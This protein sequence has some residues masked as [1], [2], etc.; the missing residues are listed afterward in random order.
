MSTNDDNS[1]SSSAGGRDQPDKPDNSSHPTDTALERFVTGRLAGDAAAELEE[2]IL[3]C[4]RCAERIDPSI[5][6]PQE[7]RAGF[8]L[9]NYVIKHRLGEGGMGIVYEAEH[10]TLR[11]RVALKVLSTRS[12][13]NDS[14]IQRFLSE[15]R[16][17]GRLHHT[18]IVPVFE[19]G[20]D[21][22]VHYYAMQLIEGQSLDRVVSD[23]RR[24]Q[25]SALTTPDGELADTPGSAVEVDHL[26][27]SVAWKFYLGKYD[28]SKKIE[29]RSSRDN[30]TKIEEDGIASGANLTKAMEAGAAGIQAGELAERESTVADELPAATSSSTGRRVRV[31]Y[32][33]RVAQIGLQVA[34]ALS[35]AH[36]H[37][38]LH[39]DIKPGN[40]LLD[41]EG[42]AWI[43]DF[44]L[45]KNQEDDLT[46]S[47]DLV[48]TFRYMAPEQFNGNADARTDVYALGLTM[49]ELCT[50][51]VAYVESDRGRLINDIF[52]EDP[53]RLRS[54]DR[55]IPKDLETIVL[56]S[57]D[58][59]PRHRYPTA[60]K[61]ATDLRLFLEDRPI[62]ARR[63]SVAE[64]AWRLCRRNP[65]SA[66]LA[67]CVILLLCVVLVGSLLHS[68]R[69]SSYANLLELENDRAV[70]AEGEAN[71]RLY[72]QLRTQIQLAPMDQRPGQRFDAGETLRQAVELL[73]KLNLPEL[74]YQEQ[75]RELRNDAIHI[76]TRFDLEE[77][78]LRR[79][80]PPWTGSLEFSSSHNWYANSDEDGNIAIRRF[81]DDQEIA[82]LPSFGPNMRAWFMRFSGNDRYLSAIYH[83]NPKRLAVW[84][85]ESGKKV[86]G[87]QGLSYIETPFLANGHQLIVGLPDGEIGIYEL[88]DEPS[89]EPVKTLSFPGRPDTLCYSPETNQLAVFGKA[90]NNLM[91]CN[92][93][94]GTSTN[95]EIGRHLETM[96]WSTSGTL[97]GACDDGSI[98]IWRSTEDLAN[99]EIVPAHRLTVRRITFL[100]GT[101]IVAT[102]SNEGFVRFANIDSGQE[103]LRVMGAVLKQSGFASNGQKIGF[104]TLENEFGLWELPREIPWRVL[105]TDGTFQPLWGLDFWPRDER[106]LA[107]ATDTGVEFWDT[108]RP[109]LIKSLDIGPTKTARFTAD[110]SKLLTSGD[111]GVRLWPVE[112]DVDSETSI[113]LGEPKVVAAGKWSR[114]AM[115]AGAARIVTADPQMQAF[116]LSAPSSAPLKMRHKW[117]QHV[118]MKPDGKWFVSTTWLGT[119]V[120]VW[121]GASG[122]ELRDL[123]PDSGSATCALS[124]DGRWLGVATG[125]ENLVWDTETW[126]VVY[127]VDR[128]IADGVP[129]PIAFSPDSRLM[130]VP[131][132]RQIVQLIDPTSKRTLGVL[133]SQRLGKLNLCATFSPS[134]QFLAVAN[135]EGIHIW[136]IKRMRERLH[137]FDL[138]WE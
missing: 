125:Q 38:V 11:R 14:Y 35:Y 13:S 79:I 10:V 111:H 131:Y 100:P 82:L 94:D 93:A 25:P 67:G 124:D 54:V 2:H 37:G 96:A 90:A 134:G 135:D 40:I 91:I 3:N 132:S 116:D 19:V 85:I 62:Q 46:R 8:Q 117:A 97:A 50:L 121:D 127:Q 107:S 22:G 12:S 59:Q 72:Q 9:G 120:K 77:T 23:V 32:H 119:G 26:R 18:N 126:E 17:A 136:D 99:P 39:R 81:A 57:I 48:G 109:R 63:I 75:R 41:R 30:Q 80:H 69:V 34:E 66:S 16:S 105:G 44:G 92:L 137:E 53:P 52:N 20:S 128:T 112:S 98:A 31:T 70:S 115:D 58:K 71:Q 15:A 108:Q 104:Y 122:K 28:R 73:P 21:A 65:I 68:Y 76:L 27:D 95:T 6:L 110:G 133:R 102:S 45:A 86:L 113:Q 78:S 64:R 130:A 114:A 56:K 87:I 24:L 29:D 47:G 55:R 4:D 51:R 129:D 88:Q 36:I 42:T 123:M 43:T 118:V 60:A 33:T 1:D 5:S 89:S 101:H 61:L 74:R 83:S 49:Y 138:D 103:L 106:I 84:D 7:P